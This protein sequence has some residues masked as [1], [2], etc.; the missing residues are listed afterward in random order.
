MYTRK[1]YETR[2]PCGGD[3]LEMS[4]CS[5]MNGMNGGSIGSFIFCFFGSH[6][7]KLKST[8]RSA[9]DHVTT[10]K[11]YTFTYT[12]LKNLLKCVQHVHTW[13]EPAIDAELKLTFA[14]LLGYD[15]R[16]ITLEHVESMDEEER[17]G[18]RLPPTLPT[19]LLPLPFGCG[20]CGCWCWWWCCWRC[21]CNCCW[22]W[23]LWWLLL[24][25]IWWWCWK[26]WGDDWL[27]WPWWGWWLF[28][29]TCCCCCWSWCGC[30]GW[31]W[32]R[33]RWPPVPLAVAVA[34]VAIDEGDDDDDDDV[35]NVKRSILGTPCSVAAIQLLMMMFCCLC[36]KF[37][38][39]AHSI[40][41]LHTNSIRSQ[42]MQIDHH[43]CRV[44]G[45]GLKLLLQRR[46]DDDGFFL[47]SLVE[48]NTT[49][50]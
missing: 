6:N 44:V 40:Y 46:A 9:R 2:I 26:W 18:W 37:D 48:F 23:W 21:C 47:H 24:L 28:C 15:F 12:M 11:T 42:H 41:V 31:C 5:E 14:S 7:D 1:K 22:W 38:S 34:A 27:L 29:C 33:W 13:M 30:C 39:L 35:A 43:F 36:Y 45:T 32:W 3:I 16:K 17:D 49:G 19:M 4:S 8:I 20:W 50:N 10:S 25:L